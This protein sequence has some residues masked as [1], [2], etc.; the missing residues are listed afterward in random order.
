MSRFCPSTPT[1]IQ[2]QRG[3][4]QRE[5]D[6][7]DRQLRD[8]CD[9]RVICPKYSADGAPFV[10]AVTR[11]R[12][13]AGSQAYISGQELV[14]A[15]V[16]TFGGTAAT[17]KSFWLYPRNEENTMPK[18]LLGIS[19][20]IQSRRSEAEAMLSKVRNRFRKS[21]Y[22]QQVV[23]MARIDDD[24]LPSETDTTSVAPSLLRSESENNAEQNPKPQEKGDLEKIRDKDLLRLLQRDLDD[25]IGDNAV[26]ENGVCNHS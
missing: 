12:G 8:Q 24:F 18:P 22:I 11:R 16:V 9:Q 5:L 6:S 15:S 26:K 2:V 3:E 4:E 25:E 7:D 10:I 20:E 19:A 1:R 23:N 21:A 13:V 14:E 17:V